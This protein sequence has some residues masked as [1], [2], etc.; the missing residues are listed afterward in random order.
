MRHAALLSLCTLA[1]A[2]KDGSA[3]EPPFDAAATRTELQRLVDE[4]PIPGLAVAIVSKDAP[5][6]EAG[7]G[8]RSVGGA[9]DPVDEHTIFKINSMTKAMG[10]T[11]I[12]ML[13]DSGAMQFDEPVSAHLPW[14]QLHDSWVS[15][16]VRISDLLT[17]RTGVF[18]NDWLDDVPHVTWEEGVRRQRFM[19]QTTP[20]RTQF[21]YCDWMYGA[22]SLAA[23]AAAANGSWDRAL[24]SRI[25]EP[26]GMRRTY[27]EIGDVVEARGL[28]ACHECELVGGPVDPASVTKVPN[29]AVPHVDVNGTL[30]ATTWRRMASRGASSVLSSAHDVGLFLQ[31]YLRDGKA[32]G[33]QLISSAALRQILEPRIMTKLDGGPPDLPGFAAAHQRSRSWD[34][35]YGYGWHAG[36]YGDEKIAWHGGSSLGFESQMLLL[37]DRG[38]G[39]VVLANY[40]HANRGVVD[41]A[42]M[43]VL[44]RV[45]GLPP[46]DWAAFHKARTRQQSASADER[47]SRLI[48]SPEVQPAESIVAGI[49]GS[50]CSPAYG[51]LHVRRER[52]GDLRLDQ[53]PERWGKLSSLAD[54]TFVVRWNGPRNQPRAVAFRFAADAG[55]TSVSI[56]GSEFERCGTVPP[57]VTGTNVRSQ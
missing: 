22:A 44:D 52:G 28:T 25:L 54:G 23:T 38:I 27:T 26:L 2:A 14:F 55:A 3:A 48:A 41:A 36:R 37:P 49:V 6:F 35:G 18:C 13:S 34:L 29:V 50:Y 33:K 20:F 10:A 19:P 32:A 21:N 7:F 53:G 31:L 17:H 12:G 30:Q 16:Q 45:L 4:W 56:G 57:Q 24:A 43:S 39:F 1:F 40:N 5:L 9:R 46:L 42:T 11:L 51:T 8:E 15:Q 47:L